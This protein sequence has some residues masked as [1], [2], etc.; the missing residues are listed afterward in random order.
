LKT[1]RGPI[2]TQL[3]TDPA[4]SH[5][6]ACYVLRI[7]LFLGTNIAVLVLLSIVFRVFGL[8]NYLY[9]QGVDLNLTALLI[10]SAAFGMGGSLISLAMSKWLAKR[11]TGAHVIE[12][13]ANSTERWLIDTVKGLAADA[14]IGMPEVAIF[15]SAQ[16]NAFATGA[17]K[18]AALVAVSSG[19]LENMNAD[20]VKA[21]LGHEVG[22]VANGDMLTLTLIQGV[23]NTFV[24]FFS[25]I[26]GFFVDRVLLR[27]ERGYG[28]GFFVTTIVAQIVLGLLASMIVMWFSRYREFR[29]DSAGARLAGRGN[30]IAALE[31][32]RAAHEMPNTMPET[33]VAFGI[34]DGVRQGLQALFA[35]HPPIADRIEALRSAG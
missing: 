12:S 18:N 30:M 34:S 4:Q 33:L 8:E 14:E 35:S 11:S 7:L 24:I 6:E 15:P 21:V 26:I 29:A 32:L 2:Y 9:S 20:E 13:P 31:R 10:F 17:S 23:L 27:N 25:R 22:H 19:L 16:P 1:V 3:G 28:I 5:E